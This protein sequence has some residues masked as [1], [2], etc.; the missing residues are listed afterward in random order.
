MPPSPDMSSA[1]GSPPSVLPGPLPEEAKGGPPPEI[2]VASRREEG[3][4]VVGGPQ[5][6]VGWASLPQAVPLVGA[7]CTPTSSGFGVPKSH[8]RPSLYR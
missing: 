2:E 7:E 5:P 1:P 3:D 4:R 6:P 8:V